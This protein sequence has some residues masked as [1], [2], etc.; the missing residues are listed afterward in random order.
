MLALEVAILSERGG[1]P[2]NEDACGHWHS[3]DQ[4]FCVVADGA[5]GHGGGEAAARLAVAHLLQNFAQ[6]PTALGDDLHRLVRTAN[7]AVR[8]GRVPDTERA[9]MYST[10]VC[11]VVDFAAHRAHWAHAGDSRLYWFRGGRII[12]QTRDHSLV[13]SLVDAGLLA[14]DQTR[15]HPNRSELRSALGGEDHETEITDSGSAREVQAGDVFLLCTDGIWEYVT[16]DALEASLAS[17]RSPDDWLAAIE[18]AVMAATQ[19]KRSHD[20]FTALSVWTADAAAGTNST[21][22]EA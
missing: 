15:T 8:E 4:L 22:Q 12:D 20:N 3:Q 6:R 19:H 18:Q 5:G 17:A 14:Q 10:V 7:Q 13:Q 16:E 2:Y 9:Q 11:L 1:R 21:H